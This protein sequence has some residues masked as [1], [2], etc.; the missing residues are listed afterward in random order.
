MTRPW[1]AALGLFLAALLFLFV[2]PQAARADVSR[3]VGWSLGS[4]TSQM[5]VGRV[6]LRYD[7]R[8]EDEAVAVAREIPRAWS[9]IEH[10]LAGDLEDSLTIHFV[11]HSGRIAEGTGMP[12]WA[13]GVAHPPTGEIAIAAHAPDGSLTDLDG[14]LRHEM[15]HVALYRAT[16]GAALPRWFHEGVAE[17]FGEEIDLMRS[18]TLAG[19]IFGS[20]VPHFEQLEQN[21]R[22]TDAITATI[23]YAA[24]R[25]FVN[26]LRWRDEDGSDLRQALAQVK[27]GKNFEAAFVNGFGRTLAELDTEWRSGLTGRFMWFPIVSGDGL[28]MALAFP[29]VFVAAVRRRRHLR[30]GWARLEAED[31]ALRAPF[32]A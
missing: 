16:G 28:P 25:D 12:Q 23:S 2:A 31:A 13:A 6:T 27:H 19:A 32:A 30:E 17:S 1:R 7:P 9:E 20:G 21:F 29:L 24:A 14:L 8:L 3:P 11:S 18:Q 4:A 5:H 10:A 26:F 15:A 22:S